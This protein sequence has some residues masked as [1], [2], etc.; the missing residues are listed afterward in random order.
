[1]SVLYF[2][3]ILCVI[4]AV[5]SVVMIT[6]MLDRKGLKTPFPL[7]G[8]FIFRNLARYREIT[9]K[10]NGKTGPLFLSFIIAIN[11]ALL[12]GCIVIIWIFRM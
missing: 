2:L 1:M 8:F 3:L 6:A 4:W 12:L 11:L 9:V 7:M 5:V 10:E